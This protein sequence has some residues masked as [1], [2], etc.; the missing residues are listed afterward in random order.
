MKVC[1]TMFHPLYASLLIAIPLSVCPAVA[2]D[3]LPSRGADTARSTAFTFACGEP[4]PCRPQAAPG[5]ADREVYPFAGSMGRPCA[6]R[7]RETPSGTRKVR[8]CF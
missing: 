2:A 5:P 3:T 1:R 4:E 7:W 6:W 8:V